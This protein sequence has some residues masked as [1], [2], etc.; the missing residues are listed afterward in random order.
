M[1]I[2]FYPISYPTLVEIQ[3]ADYYDLLTAAD[4]PTVGESELGT[5][6]F[7]TYVPK[8]GNGVL[9]ISGN[10]TATEW[11]RILQGVTYQAPLTYK[12]LHAEAFWRNITFTV[13]NLVSG[14]Y[15]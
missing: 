8:E 11:E 10:G 9:Y 15:T 4:Y 3:D 2:L 1:S 6:F 12:P 14:I 13:Y 5:V 7:P